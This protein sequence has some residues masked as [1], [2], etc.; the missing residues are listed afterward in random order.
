LRLLGFRL[1]LA[2]VPG[3]FGLAR[4]VG[5]G[6]ASIVDWA[7][8]MVNSDFSGMS[9]FDVYRILRLRCDVFVVEQQCPYPELDGRDLEP[10][11]R[12]LWVEAQDGTVAAYLRILEDAD[13]SAR[14]GRVVTAKACRGRGLAANLLAEAL[15][16]IGP[17]RPVVLDAQTTATGV[18]ERHGFE[19]T[20]PPYD[21]DGIEHVPMRRRAAV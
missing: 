11:T 17:D 15:E 6:S 16:F 19:I 3:L 21:E 13:G 1:G 9:G 2:A 18:Y 20:G 12:H 8:L 7:R 5:S 10:G 4:P 14:I